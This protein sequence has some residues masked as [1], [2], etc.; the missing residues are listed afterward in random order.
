M[1]CAVYSVQCVVRSVHFQIPGF[2]QV[3]V[4]CVMYTVQYAGFSVLPAKDED[5]AVETG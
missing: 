3:Q 4:Q 2:L 1:W 5:F